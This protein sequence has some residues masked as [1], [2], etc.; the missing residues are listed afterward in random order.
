MVVGCSIAVTKVPLVSQWAEMHK[1]AF[2]LGISLAIFRKPS[3][4]SFSS[5]AFMGL[6]CPK[7]NTGIFSV[8][9]M[10]AVSLF[11]VFNFIAVVVS[12]NKA[13]NFKKSILFNS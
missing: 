8:L 1:M 10:E 4:N 5:M 2:G 9:L 3:T 7:N 13:I 6:P 12:G 11:K